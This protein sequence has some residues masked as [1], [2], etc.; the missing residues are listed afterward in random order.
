MPKNICLILLPLL[1]LLGMSDAFAQQRLRF[2]AD[3][4]NGRRVGGERIN[5][6]IGN[7]VI[8][9]AETTIY[10]DS[11]SV[12][13]AENKAEA[14]GRIRVTEG[15]SIDITSKQ[16]VYDGNTGTAH[17]YRDVVYRDGRATLY[18]DNLEFNKFTGISSY[19]GGGRLVDE[20]NTLTSRQGSYD[21]Q[22]QQASFFG[23]VVLTSPDATATTD[24]LY[25]NTLTGQARFVG[26]YRIVR[27]DGTIV[28][29]TEEFIYNTR[30][31][32]AAVVQGF[33][34][35]QDYIITGNRLRYNK[36]KQLFTAEGKVK[37]TAKNRQIIITGEEAYYDK[38]TGVTQV[39]GN[40][41]MKRPVQ[42]DTLYLS[43]DTMR[44]IESQ[45]AAE[46]RLLAWNRVKI[47]KED[48]QGLADS[49][50]YRLADSVLYFYRDP[51]LWNV[52]NQLTGDT[53]S[54]EI[55]NNQVDRMRLLQ[56][57]FVISK[58][59]AINHYN[60]VKGR[61]IT[62]FFGKEE[63]EQVAVN[64]NA[65]SIYFV[66]DE[67]AA[68]VMMGMNRLTSSSMLISFGNRTVQQIRFYQQPDA[69]FV[70]PHELQEPQTRL[71]GFVWREEQ[72]PSKED[73]LFRKA[74][75]TP[76]APAGAGAPASSGAGVATPASKPAAGNSA[77]PVVKPAAPAA[78]SER[79]VAP[80][81]KKEDQ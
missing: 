25:Y 33:I 29:G 62:A 61:L 19:Y 4:I 56:N 20:S 6:L 24:T 53:I 52:Q 38:A 75:A 34:E 3:K 57:G 13:R 70:P 68:N 28:E 69:I 50:A 46:K 73:V 65:E 74:A 22:N 72:R 17:L 44:S 77:V 23:K 71:Q 39:W 12:Q 5:Y 27:S 81:L 49:L 35:N 15:D 55:H 10:A 7:V 32:N 80:P 1:L 79:K 21:K 47:F 64:G 59:T 66:L 41:V 18:T 48:L 40:P 36:Q 30:S 42:N 2:T 54:M 8:R 16:L 78:T 45:V 9:Q 37:M 58:D 51:V 63:L 11:A 43:A 60:Q 31:E 14:F 26:P 67:K 76:P